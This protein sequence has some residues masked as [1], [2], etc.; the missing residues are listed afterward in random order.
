MKDPK[1]VSLN[2]KILVLEY[3]SFNEKNK[4]LQ[5]T[6]DLNESN[7]EPLSEVEVL[8]KEWKE[9]DMK[10]AWYEKILER[11]KLLENWYKEAKKMIKEGELETIEDKNTIAELKTKVSGL[12]MQLATIKTKIKSADLYKKTGTNMFWQGTFEEFK[13]T[14]IK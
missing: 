4:F 6:I 12:E 1:I 13:P 14:S 7:F 9:K 8:R 2:N 5:S 10:L 11:N 3:K